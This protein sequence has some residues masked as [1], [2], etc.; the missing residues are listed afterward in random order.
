MVRIEANANKGLAGPT[1]VDCFQVQSV[2]TERL[3]RKIGQISDDEV[4][5]IVE[6]IKLVI[7]AS[8]AS[9]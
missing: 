5:K 1:A 2:S 6:S 3:V 9:R 7:E 8:T 4:A